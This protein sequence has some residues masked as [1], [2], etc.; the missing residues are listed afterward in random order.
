MSDQQ[1]NDDFTAQ[2]SEGRTGLATEF[3]DFLKDNKKW[4]LAPIIFSILGLGLLGALMGAAFGSGSSN[5]MFGAS[6]G[7]SFLTRAT[8]WLAIGFFAIAFGLA[9]IA[10]ER[11]GTVSDIGIPQ[12]DQTDEL[13]DMPESVDS[14]AAEEAATDEEFPDDIPDL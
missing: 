13:T 10:N 5:T 7:T 2:A 1:K 6:G 3:V 4:W 11:A 12:V 14:E 9:Y 8:A